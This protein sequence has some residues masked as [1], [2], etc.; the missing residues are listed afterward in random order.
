MRRLVFDNYQ[1]YPVSISNKFCCVFLAAAKKRADD[2]LQDEQQPKTKKK[3]K[4]TSESSP[5]PSDP[6]KEA[7]LEAEIKAARERAVT[8]LEIRMKQFMDMLLEKG[9]SNS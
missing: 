5:E 9:V 4:S 6:L 3:K 8:P 1:R 2:S 7:A